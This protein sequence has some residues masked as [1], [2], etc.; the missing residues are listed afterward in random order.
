MPNCQLMYVLFLHETDL[1][2]S[3]QQPN[4]FHIFAEP[5]PH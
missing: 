5:L 4:L 1:P 2:N 3:G